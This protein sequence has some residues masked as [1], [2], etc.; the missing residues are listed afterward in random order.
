MDQYIR[1]LPLHNILVRGLAGAAALEGIPLTAHQGV[2][3]LQAAIGVSGRTD[4]AK[5]EQMVQA[6]DWAALDALARHILSPAQFALFTTVAPPSGFS[7]RWKYQVD[8]EVL[9]ALQAE[10]VPPKARGPG[11]G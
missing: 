7:S 6:I 10:T 4:G 9:R 8:A 3:L 1:T 11:G 5:G 2:Q